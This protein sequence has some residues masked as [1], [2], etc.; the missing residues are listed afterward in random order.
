VA[1]GYSQ[2]AA[3]MVN[4]VSKLDASVQERVAGVV[5]YGNTRN[6]QEGGKIPNFPPEKAKTYCNASDGV[7]GGALLVT[8][9][10]LTY[11]RDV[12]EAVEYLQ[13]QISAQGSA[14]SSSSSTGTSSSGASTTTQASSGLGGLSGWSGIFGG[15]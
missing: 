1:A 15:N 13:G 8:A 11:T 3:V 12:G 14:S 9:G 10:H 5:L 6:R 7:C 4:A 2:G